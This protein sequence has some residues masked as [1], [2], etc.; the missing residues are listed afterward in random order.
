MD[1]DGVASHLWE[2]EQVVFCSDPD[3]GLR[4]VIV[5]DSTARGPGLG[6]VR[7]RPYATAT[8]AVRECRRLA[9]AMTLKNAF[10]ELPFGGAKSVILDSPGGFPDRTMA[11]RRFGEYVAAAGGRYLPGVDMGTSVDDLAAMGAAGAT[12]SCSAVDPSA[13]TA[14][15]VHA[16]IRAAVEHVDGSADLEGQ[17][18]LIQGAGHV[19]APLAELLVSDGAIVLVADLDRQRAAALADHV[20]GWAIDPDAA[21]RTPC[22]VLAPCAAAR[23]VN[24]DTVPELRCRIVAGAANDTLDSNDTA[25]S[26]ADRG[27][28]YIPDFVANAGGVIQIQAMRA[29]WSDALLGSMVDRIGDRVASVLQ[30]AADTGATPLE[31]AEARAAALVTAAPLHAVEVAA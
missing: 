14:R 9:A 7:L 30:A 29:G 22:D 1:L 26:L 5:I 4:A 28:T 18:V 21:L 2:H 12:V 25:R 24:A 10:A 20:G 3:L 19:G 15:G 23:V 6:G 13:W 31:V 8:D 27:I 17:R 16:A 11:M